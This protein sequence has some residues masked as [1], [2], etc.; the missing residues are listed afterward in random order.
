M[1]RDLF[2]PTLLIV[3]IA[4]GL[5]A[6]LSNF[7]NHSVEPDQQPTKAKAKPLMSA[8]PERSRQTSKLRSA[9][10]FA[11]DDPV[12]QIWIKDTYES[13]LIGHII[14]PFEEKEVREL[15]S[16]KENGRDDHR[17]TMLIL[18]AA[19]DRN[20]SIQDLLDRE[21]LRNAPTHANALDAYEYALTENKEALERILARH[22]TLVEKGIGS[23]DSDEIWALA[24][25]DEWDII[26]KALQADPLSGDGASGPSRYA[27]WLARRYLF[28]SHPT[29]P[30]EYHKEF[31]ELIYGEQ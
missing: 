15:L 4:C 20:R 26:L 2:L 10:D 6:W 18:R 17:L 1:N 5:F 30:R 8:L 11:E 9:S 25:V 7:R 24:Y 28:P 14:K 13:N 16:D 3:L 29:F 21:D 27:F 19:G 31:Y 23:W 22:K 12:R